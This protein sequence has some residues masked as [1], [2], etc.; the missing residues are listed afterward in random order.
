MSETEKMIEIPNGDEGELVPANRVI[1]LEEF[2]D[3]GAKVR[4]RH[5]QYSK[6]FTITK[7]KRKE[8]NALTNAL[9]LWLKNQ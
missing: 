7:D 9:L 2:E 6:V 4:I 1:I 5:G 3:G 8:L